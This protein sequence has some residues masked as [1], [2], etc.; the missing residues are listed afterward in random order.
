MKKKSKNKDTVLDTVIRWAI[1]TFVFI[2]CALALYNTHTVCGIK[3]D[4]EEAK[5]VL[6]SVVDREN[7]VE[8][9]SSFTDSPIILEPLSTHNRKLLKDQ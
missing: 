6:Q 1:I 3:S 4:L 8:R 2:S 7:G 9:A 5:R